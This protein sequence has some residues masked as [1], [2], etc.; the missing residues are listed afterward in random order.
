MSQYYTA[1]DVQNLLEAFL[2][3]RMEIDPFAVSWVVWK[4]AGVWTCYCNLQNMIEWLRG[5]YH[6]PVLFCCLK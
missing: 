1:F 6:I 2:D 5:C 4:T 3:G